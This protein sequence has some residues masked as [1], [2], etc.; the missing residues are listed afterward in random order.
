[1][2]YILLEILNEIY[3]Y[4][5]ESLLNFNSHAIEFIA[6]WLGLKAKFLISS[7]FG[8]EGN[9]TDKLTNLCM[10]VGAKKYITGHGA[11]NYLKHEYMESNGIDVEYI[12]YQKKPYKQL[13]GDFIPYVSILDVIANV[14]HDASELICSESINWKKFVNE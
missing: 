13:Y 9:K 6:R 11:F 8:A 12:N 10:K 2:L 5:D 7:S 1:L 4:Q 14:G 3:S